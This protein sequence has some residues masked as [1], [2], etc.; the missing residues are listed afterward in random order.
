MRAIPRMRGWSGMHPMLLAPSYSGTLGWHQKAVCVFDRTRRWIWPNSSTMCIKRPG[1][2]C[3]RNGVTLMAVVAVLYAMALVSGVI[4]LLPTLVKDLFVMRVG[5]NLKRMWLDMH[6][7]VGL[8]SFPFHLIMA[9][10]V[11]M[12]GLIT[13]PAFNQLFSTAVYDSDQ[14]AAFKQMNRRFSPAPATQDGSV[15][16]LSPVELLEEVGRYAPT[17]QIGHMLYV[18]AGSVNARVRVTGLVRETLSWGAAATFDATS[19]KLVDGNMLP[20]AQDTWWQKAVL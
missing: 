2:L 6:N 14:R 3:R 4:I 10:T 16:M 13:V 7:I 20:G 5:R 15:P 18:N 11:V 8:F 12:L 9:L 1:C 19:G 17:F